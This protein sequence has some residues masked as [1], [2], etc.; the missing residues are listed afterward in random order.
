MEAIFI[1]NMK[2]ELTR[3]INT[4]ERNVRRQEQLAKNVATDDLL[5]Y[6][7]PSE[8]TSVDAMIATHYKGSLFITNTHDW[9]ING[10]LFA[11]DRQVVLSALEEAMEKAVLAAKSGDVSR[12]EDALEEKIPIDTADEFG[13]TLLLLACQQGFPFTVYTSVI[14]MTVCRV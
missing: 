8:M 14:V 6:G 10:F 4:L 12:M 5:L 2:D 9:V 3:A 1:P 7:E 11:E 13:N